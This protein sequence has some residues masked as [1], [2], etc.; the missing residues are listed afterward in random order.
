[1]NYL[2]IRGRDLKKKKKKDE[3]NELDDTNPFCIHSRVKKEV[4]QQ[5]Y[6]I[7]NDSRFNLRT[8]INNVTTR[9]QLFN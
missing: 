1:M 7:I 2:M 4:I 6:C 5:Y 9:G 3:Y 8:M